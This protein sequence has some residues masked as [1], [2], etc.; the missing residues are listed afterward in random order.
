MI[1]LIS[2]V[3]LNCFSFFLS[4]CLRIEESFVDPWYMLIVETKHVKAHAAKWSDE[5][6]YNADVGGGKRIFLCAVDFKSDIQIVS[7][8]SRMFALIGLLFKSDLI[9]ENQN[10]Q[11]NKIDVNPFNGPAGI[12]V[13]ICHQK[14]TEAG[15]LSDCF[16]AESSGRLPSYFF[17]SVW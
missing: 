17:S 10:L 16:R 7:S 9:N 5:T 15:H 11:L 2:H 13:S 4:L 1:S 8:I 14:E 3:C 12:W 6:W